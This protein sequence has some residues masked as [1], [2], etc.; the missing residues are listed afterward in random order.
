[1]ANTPE[2]C[3]AFQKDLDKLEGWAEKNNLKFNKSNFLQG[4]PVGEE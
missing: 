1:M 3:E 4:P 2:S